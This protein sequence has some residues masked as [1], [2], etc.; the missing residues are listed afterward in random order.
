MPTYRYRSQKSKQKQEEQSANARERLYPGA[1]TSI[2]PSLPLPAY[3]GTYSHPAYPTI[4]L[5]VKDGA[6]YADV[7]DRPWPFALHFEH[8]AGEHFI[9][10]TS[11]VDN[12]SDK[13]IKAEFSVDA[14]G[15]AEQ[16]RLGFEE[17]TDMIEFARAL[18]S[19]L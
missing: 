11:Q 1:A 12:I 6:L 5:V 19:K 9:V 14:R 7:S 13:P 2:A 8:V 3:A 10:R 16:L 4:D 18:D 17:E 15:K